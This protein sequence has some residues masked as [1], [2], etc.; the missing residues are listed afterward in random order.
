MGQFRVWIAAYDG[1]KPRD[2]HDVPPKAVAVEP[3]EEG[4]MS[5]EQAAAYVEAFNRTAL[6]RFAKIWAVA[7]PVT[8]RYEGEPNAGATIES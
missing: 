2:C 5:V 1:W 3:A 6:R 4:T 8:V 7:L